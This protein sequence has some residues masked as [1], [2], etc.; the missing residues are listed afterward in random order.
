MSHISLC[1]QK[2]IKKIISLYGTLSYKSYYFEYC[3]L[4][5]YYKIFIVTLL[6]FQALY[7]YVCTYLFLFFNLGFS[8]ARWIYFDRFTFYVDTMQAKK[9]ELQSVSHKVKILATLT[10]MTFAAVSQCLF[11]L[12]VYMLVHL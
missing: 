3:I 9:I 6:L 5:S 1:E 4:I 8:E 11:W 12:Y 2:F 10:T 7:V